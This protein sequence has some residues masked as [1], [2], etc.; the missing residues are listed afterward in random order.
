M[1][2]PS[3]AKAAEFTM[4]VCP[5]KERSHSCVSLFQ[6]FA[7]LSTDPVTTR[8]LSGEKD[9]E[10]VKPTLPVVS[11]QMPDSISHVFSVRS[12]DV[13]F[14]RKPQS[15]NETERTLPEWPFNTCKQC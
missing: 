3:G 2:L 9:A 6:I 1:V 7:A 14:K 15:V 12:V 10:D 13:V 4:C 8:F 11:S 5:H